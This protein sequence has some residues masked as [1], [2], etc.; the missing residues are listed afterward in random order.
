MANTNQI[1][2]LLKA[3]FNNELEK[4]KVISLQIAAHEAKIG[5]TSI[6]RE[7]KGIVESSKKNKNII[8]TT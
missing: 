4:F 5:H 2:S 8:N 3:H 1:K 7:I 6:A